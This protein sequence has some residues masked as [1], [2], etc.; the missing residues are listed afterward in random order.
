MRC[1]RRRGRELAACSTVL[2]PMPEV[3]P[4]ENS[5]PAEG[6]SGQTDG[7]VAATPSPPED[8]SS[9]IEEVAFSL[10]WKSMTVMPTDA[11]DPINIVD[12]I[13]G[14]PPPVSAQD[15][16]PAE[17]A[18]PA[19]SSPASSDDNPSAADSSE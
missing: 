14:M 16:P 3:D 1:T 8:L 6:N 2:S 18:P 10:E 11:A 7:E 9:P 12:E 13:G 19:A 17:S 15:S 5:S 4:Q